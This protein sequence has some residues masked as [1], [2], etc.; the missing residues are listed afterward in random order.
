MPELA[1]RSVVIIGAGPVGCAL[2]TLLRRQGLRVRVFERGTESAGTGSGHSFN[3]TLTS[4]GLDCLPRS[5]KRRLYLQGA[6]LAKRIIHHRDGAISTQPYGTTDAHHLLSIPRRVLQD[7]LRD[8]AL[9]AGAEIHYGQACIDVDTARPAALLRGRDGATTWVT[10]DLLVGCDGANSAVREAIAAAHPQQ[11][12]V[13]REIISHGYA[14]ITMDYGDAD[15]TGMHLWPRGDHFLQAQPNRDQTFTTSL[16]KPLA[17]DARHRHFSGLPSAEAIST[18]CATQFPDVFGRMNGVGRDLATRSPGVL[19]IVTC[20]PYHHRRAV[21]V[22]DAAHAVVPFFGQGINCS[23]EDAATLA[24]LLEKCR[25]TI[26]HDSAVAARAVAEQYSDV[27][28]RAGHTL[29]ELSLRNLEELSD[30][31][32]DPLFLARRALER[33]LHELWPELYTPLYQL[34]AF[35]HMPYDAAERVHRELSAALDSL[36][37]GRDLHREQDA[38]IADFVELYGDRFARKRTG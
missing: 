24:S 18:Y 14:E 30:H 11:L 21:L 37:H 8:Q 10:G 34:V 6:V 15:P 38:I 4:R 25:S 36:C 19:R 20:A 13:T 23:F 12:W 35:T 27:R 32:N 17:G 26:Q 7:I 2:A 29:A 9:R 31:V 28:V 3:L 16:F 5:V 22:G 1:I 33:R